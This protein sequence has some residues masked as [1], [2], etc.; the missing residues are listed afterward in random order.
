V[1]DEHLPI[2]I[3]ALTAPIIYFDVVTNQG[4]RAGVANITLATFRHRTDGKGGLQSDLMAVADLR[5][6]IPALAA[7]RAAIDNA[8][9]LNTPPASSDAPQN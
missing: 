6:P 2:T 7:L 1:T 4:V 9:L 8:I 5:C 3:D